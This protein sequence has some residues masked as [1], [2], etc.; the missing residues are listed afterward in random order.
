V[1][2]GPAPLVK[3]APDTRKG[4]A[5]AYGI[6]GPD[7][8]GYHWIDSDEPGGPEY[9]WT[10]ISET[11]TPITLGDDA[12]SEVDLS[13]DF[14]FYENMYTSCFISSNGYIS[15]ENGSSVLSNES[16]PN[17]AAPNNLIAGFWTDLD[18]SNGS[19]QV[20]FQD[21]GT[22][23]VIEFHEV[24]YYGA[25]NTITFQM[26][27]H[28]GGEITCYYQSVGDG[29]DA[30][31]TTGIENA[32][33]TD[34][35]QVVF[36]SPY[37]Q[38]ELAVRISPPLRWLSV[39]DE[40]IEQTLAPGET[41]DIAVRID[42]A[43]IEAGLHEGAVEI[44]HNGA[45]NDSPLNI[46]VRLTC[47]AIEPEIDPWSEASDITYG[48]VLQ[49]SMLSGGEAHHDGQEVPGDFVFAFPDSVYNAGIH[50]A[51][52]AFLPHDTGIFSSVTGNVNITVLPR[53]VTITEVLA[54]DKVYDGTV[55]ATLSGGEPH[56]IIDG[57]AVDI[58]PGTAEFESK[59][60]GVDIPVT[61]TG[62]SLSGEDAHN[63]YLEEIR[64]IFADILPIDVIVT[65]DHYTKKAGDPDPLFTAS[66]DSFISG[67]DESV[68]THPLEF[69][70][71]PGE[72]TGAYVIT[73][74]GAEADN[75]VFE[76]RKGILTID[77]SSQIN[78]GGGTDLTAEYP[79][80]YVVNNP[81]NSADDDA[82]LLLVSKS[83]VT[84]RI[85]IFDAV[86]NLIDRQSAP[87]VSG[88]GKHSFTWDLTDMNGGSV[89]SGSF[90]AIAEMVNSQT[91]AKTYFRAMIGV[92]K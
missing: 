68:L 45:N 66:F 38:D 13:F 74:F 6:G 7:E 41:M 62:F 82:Q 44:F 65:A 32:A 15:F 40:G 34:G 29:Q 10:G 87:V 61:T 53:E 48:D 85:M 73:P 90:L 50:T 22:H 18:P 14:P 58:I 43:E 71:E 35:V 47:R 84:V 20:Y 42:A 21:F 86:G 25:T 26:V 12:F 89:G 67:E 59:N 57:D 30:S 70:R 28:A 56:G 49:E 52:V 1:D 31:A 54:A 33:G 60:V 11:G 55:A 9:V 46:P 37:I 75:Y 77:E 17:T 91:G 51:A 78:D 19:G 79:G 2:Y 8:F 3:G 4:P 36:N 81:V 64:N 63:Y 16:I 88:E 72:D 92:M 5:T 24:R 83:D 27:L 69:S 76:F 39:E 80:L 23:A